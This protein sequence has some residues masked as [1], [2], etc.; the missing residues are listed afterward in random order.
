VVRKRLAK[1]NREEVEQRLK[2]YHREFDFA[3]LYFPQA[4]IHQIDG[5]KSTASVASAIRKVLP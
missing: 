2:D 1:E 4:D 3:R 5:A